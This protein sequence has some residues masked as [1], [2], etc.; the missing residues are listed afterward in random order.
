M[1]VEVPL[2]GALLAVSRKADPGYEL[3]RF[4]CLSTLK[5]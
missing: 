5:M 2:Q 3:E 1:T 4:K